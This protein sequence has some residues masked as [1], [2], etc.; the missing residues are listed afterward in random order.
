MEKEIDFTKPHICPVYGREVDSDLCY[1]TLQCLS[2]MF[3]PSSVP[4]LDE[5]RDIEA[6]RH[7][8][9]GCEYSEL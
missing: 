8:C 1:E 9:Q 5:V 2:G 4:E 3:K 7:Q 6:A